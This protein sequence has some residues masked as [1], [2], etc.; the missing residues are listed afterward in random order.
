MR[1]ISHNR[2]ASD[3]RYTAKKRKNP[4][5][6]HQIPDF[7]DLVEE[8]WRFYDPHRP[9]GSRPALAG[10]AARIAGRYGLSAA[11][12]ATTLQQMSQGIAALTDLWRDRIQGIGAPGGR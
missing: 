7:R 11:A 1:K 6:L 12:T 10:L 5:F 3:A 8:G 2:R 9:P 4:A